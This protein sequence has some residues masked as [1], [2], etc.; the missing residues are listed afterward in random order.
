MVV[1]STELDPYGLVLRDIPDVL[2]SL[3]KCCSSLEQFSI[4]NR[5]FDPLLESQQLMDGKPFFFI[6][7]KAKTF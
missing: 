2:N 5:Q 6:K 7:K 4:E 3:L 1:A